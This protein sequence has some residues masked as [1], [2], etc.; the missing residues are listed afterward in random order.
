VNVKVESVSEVSTERFEQLRDYWDRHAQRDPLWAILSDSAKSAGR[1]DI[2][3]FFQTGVS[4]IA[5]LF[6]QLDSRRIAVDRRA[7]LDF[8]CGVGRL[9]QALAPHFGRVVGV[10]VSPRMLELAAGMNRFGS[11]VSYVANQAA[12]LSRF[13]D[14]AFDFI[15]SNIVLQHIPPDISRAYIAEF[16]RVLAPG[17][18]LIFQL[19]SHQRQPDDRPPAPAV[20]PMPDD[21][22]QAGLAVTGVSSMA[23]GPAGE[24]TLDVAVTN[25][26][27]FEWSAQEFGVIRVGNHWRD[28]SGDRMLIRDDG[29]SSLP[30][31][32]P[33]GST[34]RVPLPIR[35]PSDPGEY[36]CEIDLAHE[37]ILWFHDKG[38]PVVRS[39]C[40]PWFGHVTVAASTAPSASD[41]L[42]CEQRFATA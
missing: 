20:T 14:G 30:N 25:R 11:K 19:P 7:A 23:L 24:I 15:V 36:Y 5:A 40:E 6:Y 35:A 34:C 26:S 33:S 41:P 29:R 8:G 3:R 2:G 31:M 39:N 18:V 17:G 4:E 37:G 42:A 1:W 38:S 13:D 28:A 21:A 22:Y 10:D 16:F 32:L 27:A 12:D 9:T